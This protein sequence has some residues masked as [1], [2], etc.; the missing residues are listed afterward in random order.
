MRVGA[1]IED[2]MLFSRIDAAAVDAGASLLRVGDPAELVA[3]EPF[4]LVLVDWSARRR[5][6]AHVL[7]RLRDRTAARVILF[8]RHTDLEAHASARAAGLGPMWARSKLVSE[9][10]SLLASKGVRSTTDG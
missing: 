10:S 8:G 5:D 9:L 1:V 7:A 4:D 2:L 6:W 3:D